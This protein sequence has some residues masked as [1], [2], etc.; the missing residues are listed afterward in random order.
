MKSRHIVVIGIIAFL[1]AWLL[2]VVKGGVT[3]PEGLPGWQAF[4]VAASPVWPYEGTQSESWYGAL[5]T[6]ASAATNLVMVGLLFVARRG[7]RQWLRLATIAAFA[8]FLVN[9]QWFIRADRNDLRLG[10]Y[11]WWFSFFILAYGLSR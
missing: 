8:S 6:T 9:A 7:S 1:V 11:L 4:R 5:L 3:L 2:P 10:Y